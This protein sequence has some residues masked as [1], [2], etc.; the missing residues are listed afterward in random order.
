MKIELQRHPRSKGADDENCIWHLVVNG[1]ILGSFYGG[2]IKFY[3]DKYE[4]ADKQIKKRIPVLK[5]NIERTKRQ[6]QQFEKELKAII[7]VKRK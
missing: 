2:K 1:Y 5:R 4:W 3:E 6:L 7:V